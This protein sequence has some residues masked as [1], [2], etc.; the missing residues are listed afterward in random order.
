MEAY[1]FFFSDAVIGDYLSAT[2]SG[3]TD[4]PASKTALFAG[5]LSLRAYVEALPKV[6]GWLRVPPA[7]VKAKLLELLLLLHVHDG[8][9]QLHGFLVQESAGRSRR[10]IKQVMRAHALSDL[11]VADYARLSGRSMSDLQRGFKRE[12]GMTPSVWLR[13]VRLEYAREHV[14]G[15]QEKTADI[16]HAAGFA[17]ASHFIKAYKGRFHRTPKQQRLSPG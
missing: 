12:F 7:L 11:S 16:A 5:A 14:L 2:S 15:S 17:D 8:C 1:L 3:L 6:H 10:N 4:A 13:R 9:G